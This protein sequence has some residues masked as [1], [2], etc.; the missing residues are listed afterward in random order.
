[1]QWRSGI[2][3]I[4]HKLALQLTFPVVFS[5]IFEIK[6]NKCSWLPLKEMVLSLQK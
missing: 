2:T 1:M 6:L 5:L 3:I 4:P